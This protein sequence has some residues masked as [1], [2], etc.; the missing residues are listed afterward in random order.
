M[1]L[2]ITAERIDS[3]VTLHSARRVTPAG[4][5]ELSW[6][7]ARRF[8]YDQ[9]VTAMV[10]AEELAKEPGPTDRMW[11]FIETWMSLLALEQ[12]EW[13][14]PDQTEQFGPLGIPEAIARWWS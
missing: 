7:P 6:L 4:D 5:W 14:W 2:Y 1:T 10:T 9:A 8:T 11:W 13:P 3:N 12:S